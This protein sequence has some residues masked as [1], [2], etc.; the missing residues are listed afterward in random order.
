MPAYADLLQAV[1]DRPDDDGPRLVMA[2][3]LDEHGEP[4]RAAFIRTQIEMAQCTTRSKKYKALCVKERELWEAKGKAD[5]AITFNEAAPLFQRGRQEILDQ[6]ACDR[7]RLVNPR[8]IDTTRF[9]GP[10]LAWRR[11]FV[12]YYCDRFDDL[13]AK[14]PMLMAD[15]PIE[16]AIPINKHPAEYSSPSNDGT[17]IWSQIPPSLRP[18]L[19][20]TDAYSTLPD[21]LA[22]TRLN[23][24]FD[25]PVDAIL[26]LSTA[27]V[28][29]AKA[30]RDKP[31]EAGR[32]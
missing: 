4:L 25:H 32:N 14:L 17:F 27:L 29:E 18:H 5:W 6:D 31:R 10:L 13:R 8:S 26:A 19:P 30:K 9:I 3:F 1:L 16:H 22:D 2:N 12:Y 21:D 24:A 23:F 15:H 11:G 28:D 20:V 7:L